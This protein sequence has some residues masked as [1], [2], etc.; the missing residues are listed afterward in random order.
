MQRSHTT[1]FHSKVRFVNDRTVALARMFKF[2]MGGCLKGRPRRA[3]DMIVAALAGA[4]GCVVVT[5][6]AKHFAGIDYVNPLRKAV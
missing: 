3:L 4:R 2:E 1:N 5:D 6:T